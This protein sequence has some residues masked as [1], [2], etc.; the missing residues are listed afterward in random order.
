MPG[1]SS[2]DLINLVQEDD[3]RLLDALQ[4]DARHLLH[5][6]ELLLLLLDEIIHRLIHA[7]LSLLGAAG[8]EEAGDQLLNGDVH[9]LDA[10]A[11]DDLEAP[12]EEA[13]ADLDLDD[14]IVELPLAQELAQLLARAL[15][16]FEIG[17]FLE[18]GRLALLL[19]QEIAERR[20][21]PLALSSRGQEQVQQALL[22]VLLRLIGH[23]LHLLGAHHVHG[24]VHEIADH[25][26]DIAPDVSDLGEFRRLDLQ[27]GRIREARQA[28]RD[29]RLADARRPDHE[30]VLRN[31]VLSEIG[32]ELLSADAIAQGDGDSPLG[33]RLADD[34]LIQ[35]FD[36]LTRRQLV[37]FRQCLD[38]AREID[39]HSRITTPR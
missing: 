39:D 7:H 29:L 32:R 14:A 9:L 30:D 27:E 33:C 4:S 5:V 15:Q 12:G 6:N 21:P 28:T 8:A 25:G 18:E 38:L 34:V 37:Q 13:F 10:L 26:L 1:F 24:D 3:A 19:F 31:D 17:S 16:L 23:L 20:S 2:G 22:R 36:D 11:R 35:L